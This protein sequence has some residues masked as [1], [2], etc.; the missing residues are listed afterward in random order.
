MQLEEPGNAPNKPVES[1]EPKPVNTLLGYPSAA[2]TL[3]AGRYP[4]S[5]TRETIEGVVLEG[6]HEFEDESTLETFCTEADKKA[7]EGVEGHGYWRIKS[8]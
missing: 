4:V 2:L 8:L 6:P 3:V 1:N 7:K 5:M